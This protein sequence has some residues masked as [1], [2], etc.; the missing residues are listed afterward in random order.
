MLTDERGDRLVTLASHGFAPSGIGSE[1]PLGEGIFSLVAEH[2]RTV[3]MNNLTRAMLFGA[4]VRSRLAETGQADACREIPPP[5]I[6]GVRSLI[7]APLVAGNQLVGVISVQ[8]ESPLGFG[9][10]EGAAD[11]E[12]GGTAPSRQPCRVQR[13]GGAGP[14]R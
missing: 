10:L 5:T 13:F 9:E 6:P 7:A 4:A 3:R 1:L 11:V 14:D 8:S 2:R 12:L